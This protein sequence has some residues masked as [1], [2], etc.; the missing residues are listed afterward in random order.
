MNVTTNGWNP[1]A[2]IEPHDPTQ[3]T[4]DNER[5]SRRQVCTPLQT[6][7]E[8]LGEPGQRNQHPEGHS[9]WS[10]CRPGRLQGKH[11]A[12][13][14]ARYTVRLPRD[15]QL[16]NHG[17]FF[18]FCFC[19]RKQRHIFT[20]WW[21][22]AP[23]ATSLNTSSA[24]V[25]DL[26]LSLHRQRVDCTKWLFVISWSNW[27]SATNTCHN[28]HKT[29]S[30]LPKLK[31]SYSAM[32][33][34]WAIDLGDWTYHDHRNS[35]R[36]CVRLHSNVLSFFFIT[37]CT[38]TYLYSFRTGI[39]PV[40]E[41]H[42]SWSQTTSKGSMDNFWANTPLSPFLL[43]L[44]AQRSISF[45]SKNESER[46]THSLF[47]SI[48]VIHHT[49]TFILSFIFPFSILLPFSSLSLPLSLVPPLIF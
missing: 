10:H 7:Q 1:H 48:L 16:K 37:P 42:P 18:S 47:I 40:Q 26:P 49:H 35:I 22:I 19:N 2:S 44:A 23:R 30:Q 8:A 11:F 32:Y 13:L 14:H 39:P 25:M 33:D 3:P 6:D 27:V 17:P 46:E 4:V 29:S 43:C 12:C 45:T 28:C 36:Y 31:N 15:M 34:E 24:K 41:P 38:F 5:T 21:S 20:W 9:P